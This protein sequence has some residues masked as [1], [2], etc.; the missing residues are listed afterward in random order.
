MNDIIFDGAIGD[1]IGLSSIFET[2]YITTGKKPKVY[3]NFPEIFYNNPYI[4]FSNS[5]N[6]MQP[7]L[8]PCRVYSCNIIKHYFEQLN[9]KYTDVDKNKIYLTNDE[10]N[11]AKEELKAFDGYKK[12]AVCLYS[13]AES[14][15]LKYEYIK[16][17]LDK[18]KKLNTKLIFFGTK[19]PDDYL[20]LFDKIVVGQYANG[21]RHV[22]S[23]M[24]ECD[25]Y[26]G[27]DTGLFHAANALGIPQIVFFRNNGCKNN[28]YKNTHSID[29]NIKCSEYCC[30]PGVSICPET[31]KCMDNFNID[32]YYDIIQKIINDDKTCLG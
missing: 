7:N 28:M 9:L 24:N 13:S 11:L 21:L 10:I 1:T 16:E 12:I 29:S 14:R 2:I 20:Q 22:F 31:L 30:S 3:T 4:E 5:R 26:V 32:G 25:M 17:L 15:D 19:Y 23:L 8:S 27:V 18:T 6:G